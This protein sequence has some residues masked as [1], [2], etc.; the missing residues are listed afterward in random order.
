[1]FVLYHTLGPSQWSTVLCDYHSSVA[2]PLSASTNLGKNAK[3]GELPSN[4][5]EFRY[6]SLAVYQPFPLLP[7]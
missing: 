6:F 3:L 4:L 2:R 5:V 7:L 1:M